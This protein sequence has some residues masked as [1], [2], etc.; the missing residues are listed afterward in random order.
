[1]CNTNANYTMYIVILDYDWLKVNR[2]FSKPVISRKKMK[3]FCGN[4]ET[5]FSQNYLLH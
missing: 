4:F 2:K 5:S 1:M 3:I